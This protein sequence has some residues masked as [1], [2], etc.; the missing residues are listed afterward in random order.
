MSGQEDKKRADFRPLVA[1]VLVLAGGILVGGL[2]A[3]PL[4]HG[5]VGLGRRF[6]A[7]SALRN[8][9]FT[10]V[11]ARC[12]TV[13]VL[14][15]MWPALRWSGMACRGALGLRAQPGWGRALF[16]GLVW[17]VIAV[18]GLWAAGWRLGAYTWNPPSAGAMVGIILRTGLAACVVGLLEEFFFRGVVYGALRKSMRWWG[19][20]LWASVFYA[21]LHF[22]QPAPPLGVVHVQWFSG[23]DL[24]R[25]VPGAGVG[26]SN[27][28]PSIGTLFLA[29]LLLCRLYAQ[30][31][32]LYFSIGLH[33]GWVWVMLMGFELM[34]REP[35]VH[36]FLF[37][38]SGNVTRTYPAFLVALVCVPFVLRL[39]RVKETDR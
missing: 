17:G 39:V 26:W 18:A 7:L 35:E 30:R 20:A 25:Q 29:G 13:V 33:A 27:L 21:L 28:W 37:G 5:L 15:A 2:L 6:A 32:D 4:F 38:T 34:E 22:A 3:P 12:V 9:E 10:A 8:I 36:P 23:W 14:A 11:A 31:G 24:L 19:A 16:T 1:V